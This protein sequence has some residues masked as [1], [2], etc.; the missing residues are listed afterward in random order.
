[1]ELAAQHYKALSEM[2]SKKDADQEFEIRFGKFNYNKT[3][4]VT[5]FE[6]NVDIEFFYR[7]NQYFDWSGLPKKSLQISERIFADGYRYTESTAKWIRKQK[8]KKHDIYDYEMRLCLSNE[9][10]I[11]TCDP[12]E[13]CDEHVCV[14]NKSRNR[15]Q[16]TFGSI[17]L[18]IVDTL[19]H[20]SPFVRSYEVEVEVTDS[21]AD[22]RSV[23]AVIK[24]ILQ[25]KQNNFFV[26]TGTEQKRVL[27][28]Y[29]ALVN[30]YYFV[31]AQP[32]TLQKDKLTQLY[33]QSYSVTDKA[34][35][36]RYFLF[37]DSESRVY[38]IDSNLQRILKTDIQSTFANTIVDG[39]VVRNQYT[40][41][42][43]AFDLLCFK[44]K[45]LRG[46]KNYL[47]QTR[48][49][50]LTEVAKNTFSNDRYRVSVKEYIFRNVFL[51]SEVLLA[52]KTTK[53][54]KNDGLIFTPM[55][56]PYPTV[57]KWPTLYKWK[58][59]ELNTIDFY[60]VRK[61][62]VWELYVQSAPPKDT[63]LDKLGPRTSSYTLFD[64]NKICGTQNM[65][66]TQYVTSTTTFEDDLIDPTTYL[67]F[68]TNTVIEYR[69]DKVNNK[70]VPLRT[71]WDKT[72]NAKKHGNFSEVAC[73]IFHNILNP[74]EQ[75]LLFRFCVPSQDKYYEKMRKFH[76]KIKE[77]LYSKY[78]NNSKY[79]LE[80]CS[81]RG[82]DMHKWVYNGVHNVHG[83]DISEKN[84]A[85]C[86]RRLE[87]L[88]CNKNE[89]FQFWKLD[90]NNDDALATISNRNPEKFDVVCCHFGMHY[91]DP[92]KAAD[93][94][95]HNLKDSG[96]FIMTFM[97][98]LKVNNLLNGSDNKYM[99]KKADN[100]IVYFIHQ[101]TP[102]DIRIVLNG[103]NILGEGSNESLLD[104]ESLLKTF[105][106]RGLECIDSQTFQDL[107]GKYSDITKEFN[108]FEKDISFLNS[109]AVFRKVNKCVPHITRGKVTTNRYQSVTELIDLHTMDLQAIKI[110]SNYDIYDIMNCIEFKYYKNEHDH[111]VLNTGEFSESILPNVP[112]KIVK[113]VYDAK[114]YSCDIPRVHFTHYLHTIEKKAT[115]NESYQR[116]EH[117][118]WYILVHKH[119]IFFTMESNE[120]LAGHD[121]QSVEQPDVQSVEQPDVQSVEQ[122]AVQDVDETRCRSLVVDVQDVDEL[123]AVMK[124]LSEGNVKKV[125]LKTLKSVLLSL[126]LKTTGNKDVLIERLKQHAN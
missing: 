70:F 46:D 27:T 40:I 126:G 54:Y 86:Y 32:E 13:T 71:R 124:L 104:L 93:I 87:G 117:N 118:N 25:L 123:K 75:E 15:Y 79:L 61:E 8:V 56:E 63:S 50:L 84:I 115:D 60:S 43:L 99:Y 96:V 29:R 23:L 22:P 24:D 88:R 116:F 48:L 21:K 91:L 113:N 10:N 122:L 77:T 12:K 19:R 5:T 103:N 110:Q 109:Y 114:D 59:A 55:D 85:E 101:Q 49:G 83:Y 90:L 45:D 119:K 72:A 81:G 66:E 105:K 76:N 31:G 53:D 80:M 7:L 95:S 2:I 51:G 34:D 17:D 57:R 106:S 67:P 38:F 92:E 30:S 11:E 78:C 36:E 4:K 97:D 94:I 44:G 16:T 102:N 120:Q 14:R 125:T 82:G 35:G 58:P 20:E 107:A 73:N 26:I 69:F 74:V 18:T 6:S 100:E 89:N 3:T 68:Q 111:I 28:E 65:C 42:F 64:I 39:E 37:I 98:K 33:K 62:G 1:M 108:E 9:Q 47:L 41:D 121:V 112:I 52:T